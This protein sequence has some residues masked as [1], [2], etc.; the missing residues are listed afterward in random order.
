[1]RAKALWISLANSAAVLSGSS[2]LAM[3]PTHQDRTLHHLVRCFPVP[4]PGQIRS[5]R[6]KLPTIVAK[7]S[8]LFGPS[9]HSSRNIP[10][11]AFEQYVVGN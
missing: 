5:F 3:G 9:L 11:F 4:R 10:E 8:N 2:G 6:A 1:M 7:V